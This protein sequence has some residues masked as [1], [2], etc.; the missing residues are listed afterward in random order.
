MCKADSGGVESAEDALDDKKYHKIKPH[1]YSQ[2]RR[3]GRSARPLL[4]EKLYGGV[5]RMSV[6]V[7]FITEYEICECGQV[8]LS[9]T[10]INH[11]SDQRQ[12]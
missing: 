2:G 7:A 4:L 10:D 6:A 1:S 9:S 5:E 11:G 3:P 12:H 8:S